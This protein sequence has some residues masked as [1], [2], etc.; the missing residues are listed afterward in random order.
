VTCQLDTTGCSGAAICGDGVADGDEA[1]DGVDFRGATCSTLDAS[2]IG[3][4]L[5]C[6]AQCTIRTTGC[7]AGSDWPIGEPCETIDQCPGGRCYTEVGDRFAGAPGGACVERCAEDG[8]C[9]LSGDAGVCVDLGY[10]GFCF[11]RCDLQNPQCRA[12]YHCLLVGDKGACYPSCT[13]DAQCEI[14][15]QCDQDSGT[16]TEGFCITP[17]ESCGNGVDDDFDG[18]VDCSD[19]DCIGDPACATGED[20]FSEGDEDGDGVADCEDGECAFLGACSG[21]VC[22]AAGAALGCG[23]T[24]TGQRNDA[25]GATSRISRYTCLDPS[26]GEDVSLGQRASSEFGY[27]LTVDATQLVTVSLTGMTS[28]LDVVVIK[29]TL[30]EF[31]DPGYGCFAFGRSNSAGNEAA[32]FSAYPGVTYYVVVDGRMGSNSGFD[33]AVTCDATG[34]ETCGNGVDDDGDGLVDCTD[35]ECLD[36][37]PSCGNP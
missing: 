5:D 34:Y 15:N 23:T 36:V 2:W 26:T 13:D 25:A 7:F 11:A 1:C 12:G 6:S 24:L 9:P 17:A 10:F 14:T 32:T 4:S 28:D 21:L 27:P 18:R 30:G 16:E 19:P 37:P 31:C 8:S 35:P 22:P 3:G 29:Q 20:C 33:L